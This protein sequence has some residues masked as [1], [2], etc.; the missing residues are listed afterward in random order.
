MRVQPKRVRS[1]VNF[2]VVLLSLGHVA[3]AQTGRVKGLVVSQDRGCPKGDRQGCPESNVLIR[4]FAIGSQRRCEPAISVD[5]EFLLIGQPA[6]SAL[7][8]SAF[9]K[10]G[11]GTRYYGTGYVP[12]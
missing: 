11:D 12:R 8:I 1:L 10:K 2:F 7:Q 6:L 4:P 5:G 9:L 3:F